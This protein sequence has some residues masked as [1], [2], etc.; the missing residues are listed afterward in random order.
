MSSR[1]PIRQQAAWAIEVLICWLFCIESMLSNRARMVTFSTAVAQHTTITHA[2][3]GSLNRR[4]RDCSLQQLCIGFMVHTHPLPSIP[5]HLSPSP[6]P[7]QPI[8]I[9]CNVHTL[10]KKGRFH[11][12]TSGSAKYHLDAVAVQEH[13]WSTD[14]EVGSMW[15]SEQLY[16]FLYCSATSTGHG[17]VDYFSTNGWLTVSFQLGRYHQGYCHWH[18]TLI[19]K[20]YSSPATCRQ[21]RPWHMKKTL[22][23]RNFL[24]TSVLYPTEFP[25][26]TRLF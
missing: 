4:H 18:W 6:I 5:K 3:P 16:K 13:Q 8:P 25:C 26:R 12:L 21:S 15:D 11:K 2:L 20:Q 22:S 10:K 9:P 14:D 24:A 1:E 19:P 23:T 7:T 17:S